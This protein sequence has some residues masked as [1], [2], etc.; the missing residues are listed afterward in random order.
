MRVWQVDVFK[1]H[2]DVIRA[3]AF[4]PDSMVLASGAEDS[5]IRLYRIG[6]IT[7]STN[8]DSKDRQFEWLPEMPG[9]GYMFKVRAATRLPA[10]CV[11]AC[12]D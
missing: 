2:T 11:H 5:T 4:S 10:S 12:V 6:H 7:N 3:V 9:S 8:G 1:G